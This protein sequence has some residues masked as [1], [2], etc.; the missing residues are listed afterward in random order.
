MLDIESGRSTLIDTEGAPLSFGKIGYAQAAESD[1]PQEELHHYAWGS[2]GRR[3]VWPH[4]Q[5][6][7][8]E[9]SISE[10]FVLFDA[11]SSTPWLR[12]VLRGQ[13]SKT[14]ALTITHATIDNFEARFKVRDETIFPGFRSMNQEQMNKVR[15]ALFARGFL[16][17]HMLE[18]MIY[19]TVFEPDEAL[20]INS[21]QAL[22]DYFSD[23]F[24]RPTRALNE[25]VENGTD[26]EAKG[27]WLSVVFDSTPI[28]IED[29][30]RRSKTLNEQEI[31]SLLRAMAKGFAGQLA[32]NIRRTRWLSYDLVGVDVFRAQAHRNFPSTILRTAFFKGVLE[33]TRHMIGDIKDLREVQDSSVSVY[34]MIE[35]FPFYKKNFSFVDGIRV[36]S[37]AKRVLKQGGKLILF[38]WVAHFGRET[39]DLTRFEDFLRQEG[40]TVEI[41]KKDKKT[42]RAGMG[43]R[44]TELVGRSPVF[45]DTGNILPVL[46]ATKIA[47]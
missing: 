20:D 4:V 39:G 6:V 31:D 12:D 15:A 7:L 2:T 41:E 25:V 11:G 46:V 37:E 30:L 18:A 13:Y 45:T 9:T 34:S 10:P 26:E 28:S 38:P 35:C 21:P 40:F 44:E 47:A 36:L 29:V 5:T 17:R 42:L 14:S 27:A 8:A 1:A 32:G 24:R 23:R 22:F 19:D 16:P 33:S 43:K 3:I